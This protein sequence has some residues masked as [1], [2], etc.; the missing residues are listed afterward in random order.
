MEEPT[1]S[2]AIPPK[3]TNKSRKLNMMSVRYFIMT[4]EIKLMKQFCQI[5][6]K[7]IYQA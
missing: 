4:S 7:I 1:K 5:E 2:P 6:I 3:A